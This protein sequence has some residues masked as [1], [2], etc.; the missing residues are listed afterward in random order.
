MVGGIPEILG[1]LLASLLV[2]QGLGHWGTSQVAQV[3]S[4][5]CLVKSQLL[6]GGKTLYD[7]A[8][9]YHLFV[10]FMHLQEL[11]GDNPLSYGPL[12]NE[13]GYSI[14]TE[15]LDDPKDL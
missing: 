4:L 3:R 11:T 14:E 5:A 12:G 15:D 1:Q 9:T 10:N 6:Q 8:A 7:A 13:M 2:A